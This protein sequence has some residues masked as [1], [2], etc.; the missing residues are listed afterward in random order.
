MQIKVSETFANHRSIDL[1]KRSASVWDVPQ[2]I[3]RMKNLAEFKPWFI[4][5]RAASAS[6][7]L[8]ILT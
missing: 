2:A 3:E 8:L 7:M 5:V 1:I 4:E 6:L